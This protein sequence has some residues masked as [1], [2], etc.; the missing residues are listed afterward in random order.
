MLLGFSS[1]GIVELGVE[2]G[3]LRVEE[4]A[5]LDGLTSS[6]VVPLERFL[7]PFSQKKHKKDASRFWAKQRHFF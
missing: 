7:S 4:S 5:F 2:N 6:S 1:V 3:D